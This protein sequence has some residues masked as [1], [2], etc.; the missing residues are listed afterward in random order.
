MSDLAIFR[1]IKRAPVVVG[2]ISRP[3]GNLPRFSYARSYLEDPQ[4]IPLSQTLPLKDK[5]FDE[6]ILRPYFEGLLPEGAARDALIAQLQIHEEDYLSILATDGLEC[7]GDVVATP[8]DEP[9]AWDAGSYV[10]LN[11]DEL[12]AILFGIDSLAASNNASRLLLPGT[13]GK[14]GLAHNP[15]DP[16]GTGW[17]RPLGGAASTHILKVSNMDR[18]AEFEL[19]CMEAAKRCGLRVAQTSAIQVAG[20]VV[21][22]S[23]RF[24]R[25]VESREGTLC[26]DRLHQED[27]AQAFGVTPRSKYVELKGGSYHC[28]SQLLRKHST[29]VLADIEELARVAIFNYL[30]GN[31]DNHL[32]NL[33]VTYEGA[34]LRLAPA[35]DLVCTT[36]FEQYSRDMGMRIGHT[37]NIDGVEGEDFIALAKDIGLGPRRM[38]TLCA[39]IAD[40]IIAAVCDAGDALKD[41]SPTLPYSAEDIADD[42]SPRLTVLRTV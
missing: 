39:D 38:R 6:R 7:I 25:N 24:D 28:I 23:E 40:S 31:C 17:S 14:V 27:M 11:S 34:H 35:Y 3:S 20:K 22:V 26:V 1:I 32:K 21:C 37:R 18:I 13:Q 16:I 12:N 19:I 2:H 5:P 36:F 9:L 41:V 10:A 8:V 42:L 15:S 33:S 30:I 4:A 29:A